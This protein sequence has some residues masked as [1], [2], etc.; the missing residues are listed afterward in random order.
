MTR[1]AAACAALVTLAVLIAVTLRV[2]TDARAVFGD[3][4][5]VGAA[6]DS[7]EGRRLSIAVISADVGA[8]TEAARALA[9]T[10]AADPLVEDVVL[11]PPSPDPAVV[12]W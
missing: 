4:S 7:P 12:A 1:P 3:A 8:R 9:E 2:E 10:L 5:S 11:G 6:L